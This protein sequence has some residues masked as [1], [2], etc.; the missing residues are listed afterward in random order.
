[1]AELSLQLKLLGHGGRHKLVTHCHAA[2]ENIRLQ[3]EVPG[4]L[5]PDVLRGEI[6]AYKTLINH[7]GEIEKGPL[8]GSNDTP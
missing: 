6:Q 8:D 4:V 2:I 7:C 3:L 1:M 5:H